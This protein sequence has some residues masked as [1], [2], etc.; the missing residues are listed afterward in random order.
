MALNFENV[1]NA[2]K[3]FN[4]LKKTVLPELDIRSFPED[5]RNW[6]KEEKTNPELCRVYGW[7][8]MS[9]D[10]WENII[11]FVENPNEELK[12]KFHELKDIVENSSVA[13]PYHL[14]TSIW[15]FGWF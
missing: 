7:G 11:F 3:V 10:G 13:K 14:N 9:N 15:V 2:Y 6:N 12:L 8:R 4:E 5:R 1:K